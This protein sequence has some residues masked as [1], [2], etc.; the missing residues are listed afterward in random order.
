APVLV[1]VLVMF[2]V[3]VVLRRWTRRMLLPS[4]GALLAAAATITAWYAHDDA[5][6]GLLPTR[7][8]I[9]TLDRL[10]GQ[11]VAAVQVALPPIA[12]V[13]GVGLLV[14]AGVALLYLLADLLAVPGRAPAWAA[15]PPL[16]AGAPQSGAVALPCRAG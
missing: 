12:D 10:V 16:A 11:G 14:T 3:L 2:G 5:L 9:G 15:L 8:A 1:T 6:L 4:L 7:A 13:P